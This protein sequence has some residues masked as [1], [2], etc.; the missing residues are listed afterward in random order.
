MKGA[1]RK[2]HH[3]SPCEFFSWVNR[4]KKK[5][6]KN[7]R[8]EKATHVRWATYGCSREACCRAHL[9]MASLGLERFQWALLMNS[10]MFIGSS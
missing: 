9:E 5:S 4:L 3:L 2:N 1:F 7:K 10:F 6:V 8:R